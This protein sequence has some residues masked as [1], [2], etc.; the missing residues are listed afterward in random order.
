MT[1]KVVGGKDTSGRPRQ[2]RNPAPSAPSAETD[3]AALNVRL[4]SVLDRIERQFEETVARNARLDKQLEE[5]A[6]ILARM[7]VNNSWLEQLIARL[8]AQAEE[9]SDA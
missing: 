5:N 7:K 4:R 3:W 1:L 8:E 2:R 9:L 6:A